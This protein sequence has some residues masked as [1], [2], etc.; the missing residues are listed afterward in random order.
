MKKVILYLTA[1]PV[2]R[3]HLSVDKEIRDVKYEIR[4]SKYGSKFVF[5]T[6]T[7][8]RPKD[9]YQ[10]ILEWHPQI[11]HF[12]GHGE[13]NEGIVFVDD[14]GESI[15]VSNEA[16]ESFFKQFNCIEC[17]ILNACYSTEQA[18]ILMPFVKYIVGTNHQ[19]SDKAA[20]EFAASFYNALGNGYSVEAA[21]DLSQ[22]FLRISQY[23]SS[24]DILLLHKRNEII[25]MQP[26]D[27]Q[28]GA[29]TAFDSFREV[30][31]EIQKF[32]FSWI[33]SWLTISKNYQPEIKN[34][35]YQWVIASSIGLITAAIISAGPAN[36]LLSTLALIAA[37]TIPLFQWLIIKYWLRNV[38]SLLWILLTIIGW[39]AGLQ[40][41]SK[42]DFYDIVP[43]SGFIEAFESQTP[44]NSTLDTLDTL[45]IY[46][47]GQYETFEVRVPPRENEPSSDIL[48]AKADIAEEK[49]WDEDGFSDRQVDSFILKLIAQLL[50]GGLIVGLLQGILLNWSFLSI[51]P[52]KWMFYNFLGILVGSIMG[53]P[54]IL[55][56]VEV[57]NTRPDDLLFATIVGIVY[58][59]VTGIALFPYTRSEK[60]DL[61]K[62]STSKAIAVNVFYFLVNVSNYVRTST[63][64]LLVSVFKFTYRIAKLVA[65]RISH[66]IKKR[67]GPFEPIERPDLTVESNAES[68]IHKT[69][70]FN[71]TSDN[72]L[73][74]NGENET[75]S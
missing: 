19:I 36:T 40:F 10:G 17:I 9:L 7:A 45:Q 70:I 5:E 39:Y 8:A 32:S 62:V 11:V 74:S 42:F 65:V 73:A 63:A 1:N 58:G 6:I 38:P 46:V 27:L 33:L 24:A 49:N 52:I 41:V 26:N 71:A 69:E 59:T 3:T 51:N 12:S 28:E 4:R 22:S 16:L 66:E 20:N 54:I 75:N 56:Y 29:I 53:V 37:L 25:N 64:K 15:N 34:L 2:D 35:L 44:I 55:I 47:D 50:T 60:A 14:N 30:L 21:F 67:Q 31:T 57:I 68:E 18:K 23:S 61:A 72:S 48:E 43:S 13:G